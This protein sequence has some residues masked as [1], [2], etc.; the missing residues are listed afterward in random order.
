MKRTQCLALRRWLVTDK[1]VLLYVMSFLFISS[2]AITK[3][4][5]YLCLSF[6]LFPKLPHTVIDQA[7][8]LSDNYLIKSVLLLHTSTAKGFRHYILASHVGVIHD[9]C[10]ERVILSF[11][12][13]FLSSVAVSFNKM[14]TACG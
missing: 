11:V 10:A 2:R 13:G 1:L 9:S 4:A 12:F 3:K 14:L 7:I 6:S 5:Y 8:Q